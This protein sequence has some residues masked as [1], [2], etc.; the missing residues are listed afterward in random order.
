[1]RTGAVWSGRIF[2]GL[3]PPL[4]FGVGFLLLW[5][6]FVLLRDIEPFVLPKPSAI[7]EQLR[8]NL[9]PILTATPRASGRAA[10]RAPR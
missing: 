1:V 10:P 3:W 8:E 7:F 5:E 2:A 6:V 4:L 9:G